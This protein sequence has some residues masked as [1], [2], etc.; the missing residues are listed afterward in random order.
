MNDEIENSENSVRSNPSGSHHQKGWLRVI[1]TLALVGILLIAVAF[2]AVAISVDDWSRDFSENRAETTEEA[3]K[4]Y[5]RPIH[6]SLSIKELATV[7]ESQVSELP[8]WQLIERSDLEQE[9]TLTLTRTTPIM[10]YVDDIVVTIRS[11]GAE[12]VINAVSQS[13]IGKGDLGQNPRNIGEL[14]T[15]VRGKLNTK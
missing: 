14:F 13:R 7:I 1:L 4:E 15:G 9:T 5:L 6:S 3:E 8:R 12:T 10:K 2:G 11:E